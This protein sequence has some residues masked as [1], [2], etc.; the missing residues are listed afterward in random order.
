MIIQSKDVDPRVKRT[1]Q[2]LQRAFMELINEKSFSAISVQDITER[3]TVNRVTFYAHFED[4]YA[5][6]ECCMREGFQQELAQQLADASTLRVS[7][8]RALILGV[9]KFFTSVHYV[10]CLPRDRQFD[11][12]LEKTI[13]QE[14]NTMLITWLKQIPSTHMQRSVSIETVA[15]VMSCAICGSA[16]QWSEHEKIFSAEEMTRQVMTVIIG[17]LSSVI[18]IPLAE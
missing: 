18:K 5:I 16:I 15:T 6:L 7:T 1:R 8:L 2:L 4:K 13:Q 3:A 11:P 10:H 14:L 17:G 9:F 12:L